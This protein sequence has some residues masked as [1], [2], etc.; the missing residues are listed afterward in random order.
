MGTP[1]K[2]WTRQAIEVAFHAAAHAA[3][4]RRLAG[5]AWREAKESGNAAAIAAATDARDKARQA[6][7]LAVSQWKE[8]K[9]A[10]RLL[11]GA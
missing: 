11:G 4:E 7:D 6:D 8:A 10:R 2:E 1:A 9:A 5:I 3:I